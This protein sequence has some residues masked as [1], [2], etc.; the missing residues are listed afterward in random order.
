MMLFRRH[1][2]APAG[3]RTELMEELERLARGAKILPLLAPMLLLLGAGLGRVTNRALELPSA[4][5]VAESG[6]PRIRLEA[7]GTYMEGLRNEGAKTVEHA[8][9]YRNHVSPVE[10]ALQRRGVPRATAKKIAWPLVEYSYRKGLDPAT[11]A[12]V[13]LTESEGKPRA[14]SSVGA[15]GLMQVMPLW[16]GKW[17]SCKDIPSS[18]LYDI[19]NNLCHGTSILAYY[20]RKAEG[21]ERRALLGYNGCVRGTNTPN[22]KRYPDKVFRLRRSI[23]SDIER[24]RRTA[25]IFPAAAAE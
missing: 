3:R 13:L 17:R 22:C 24:A 4:S 25:P 8:V 1:H 18:D 19:E 20:V 10:R 15:R 7:L 6:T 14:T 2:A 11:V 23:Q 21:D 16:S 12:S 5:L 9:F